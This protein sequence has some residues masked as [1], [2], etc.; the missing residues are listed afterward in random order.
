PRSNDA[1][2]SWGSSRTTLRSRGSSARCCS[3]RATSGVCSVV[4]CSLKDYKRS[5]T[6]KPLGCPPWSTEHESNRT[7]TH[8][9][10]HHAVGHDPQTSPGAAAIGVLLATG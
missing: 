7:R 4:T 1:R 10:V 2:T 8:E 3:S 9:L 5:P 6:I